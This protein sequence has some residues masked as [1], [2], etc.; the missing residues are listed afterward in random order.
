[1]AEQ[2][3]QL[4]KIERK[5][6]TVC[7]ILTGNSNPSVGLVVRFDRVEQTQKRV[8]WILRSMTG[9]AIAAAIAGIIVA[10]RSNG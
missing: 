5:L 10:L 7:K 8:R 2:P 1:M 6:D 4:D 3:T 9:A